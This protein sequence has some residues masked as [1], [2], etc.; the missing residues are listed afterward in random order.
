MTDIQT[1]QWYDKAETVVN[2]CQNDEQLAVALN[3]IEL[4]LTQTKDV[5]G[6]TVLLRKFAKKKQELGL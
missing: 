5:S 2:S 3:Y 4:Y 1:N 6:Y